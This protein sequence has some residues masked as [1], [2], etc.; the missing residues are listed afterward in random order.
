MENIAYTSSFFDVDDYNVMGD[1]LGRYLPNDVMAV[2]NGHVKAQ[3]SAYLTESEDD[4]SG[5]TLSSLRRLA[6]STGVKEP[7]SIS[8]TIELIWAIQVATYHQPCFR[9]ELRTTCKK[10]DCNWRYECK[11]PIADYHPCHI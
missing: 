8:H 11:K 4:N 3:I 9:S 2:E 10:E 1:F 5:I 6:K 7:E